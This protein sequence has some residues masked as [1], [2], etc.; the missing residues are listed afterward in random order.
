MGRVSGKVAFI[1]GA[2]RG[3]GRSHAITLAREGADIIAIDLCED[4]ATNEYA[5]SRESDLAETAKQVEA[6]DRRIV[7]YK[8]D[9]RSRSQM[10]KAV[11]D[12]IAALGKIDIVCAN[13]GICPL[14]QL[15]YQAWIDVVDVNL[16]GVINAVHA[17]LPHMTAGGSIIATGSL[18]AFLPNAVDNPTQGPGGAGYGF[19]KKTVA[20]FIHDLALQLGPVGIR[21]NA[22]HPTN[23]NTAMI[24]SD[25]MYRSF[26]PDIENPTYED[27]LPRFPAMTAMGNP[28]VEPYD[29]SNA[30]LFLASDEARYVTGLQLR[31]DAGGYLKY[32]AYHS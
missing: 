4:I 7:T 29:I 26:C 13:A 24:N 19:A 1:T 15:P 30:V 27:A 20:N 2:A 23:C 17:A 12:G 21:A 9:V 5:M 32:N 3:Q 8:A 10:E 28:F 25:L 14:G 18:A 22:V 31:V 16:L 11:S 6:L